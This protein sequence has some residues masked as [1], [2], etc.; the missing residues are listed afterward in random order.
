MQRC[1]AWRHQHDSIHKLQEFARLADREEVR[2]GHAEAGVAEVG[3][4]RRGGHHSILAM[5]ADPRKAREL[6]R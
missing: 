2:G 6:G 5:E 1:R 3:V 4:S